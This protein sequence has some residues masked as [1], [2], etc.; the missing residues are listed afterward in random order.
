MHTEPPASRRRTLR[1][2]GGPRKPAGKW[3]G[4]ILVAL[5]WISLAAR[6]CAGEVASPPEYQITSWRVEEGLPQSTVTCVAQAADGYLW[7]GTQNGLVRFDGVKF[8]VFDEN[9]TPAIKN[10]RIVQLLCEKDG[11]VWVGT[12]HGG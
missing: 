1:I 4:G 7:L 11:T 10:S 2:S 3:H 8:R 12:E 6:L 9:N 5:L